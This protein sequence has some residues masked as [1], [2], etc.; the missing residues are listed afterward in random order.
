MGAFVEMSV[1]ARRELTKASVNRYRSAKRKDKSSLLNEF[2]AASGYNRDYAADLLRTWGN[3]R[4]VEPGGGSPARQA[5][6]KA[7]GGRPPVYGKD[8]LRIFQPDRIH[9]FRMISYRPGKCDPGIT[10]FADNK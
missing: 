5:S 6:P 3:K 4:K 7:K 8:V 9:F 2:C 10:N 1:K